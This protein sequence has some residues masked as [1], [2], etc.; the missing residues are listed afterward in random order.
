M[1]LTLFDLIGTIAFAISGAF[2]A[3]G[4][5]MDL[6]GVIMLSVT[7][8]CGGGILRDMI[9]GN[10]P[11]AMFTNPLYVSIAAVTGGLVFCLLYFH[12]KMPGSVVP[13]YDQILFWFDTLG[14]AAFTV[15]GVMIGVHTGYGGNLF[16][17]VFLGFIT[18]VGGG[19]LRD[20][21][22]SQLPYIFQK[23]VYALASIL[24]AIVMC[25]THRTGTPW[26]VSMVIGF[27]VIVATRCLA[28][29]FGWNL[30]KAG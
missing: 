27:T 17:L 29:H 12:R 10:T 6:F 28:R 11:P 15:D 25:C 1:L 4:K 21:L 16:L 14:L 23:H 7:T 5:K 20:V 18:G 9:I 19:V 22:A 8:A 26:S 30:P 24:G 3:A 13:L 2:V